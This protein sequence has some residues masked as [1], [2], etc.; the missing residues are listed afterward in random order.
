MTDGHRRN[1][2]PR[3]A[4][5]LEAL[6]AD[7]VRLLDTEED[8]APPPRRPRTPRPAAPAST[9]RGRAVEDAAA[10]PAP[11]SPASGG[12]ARKSA[13]PALVKVPLAGL[14]VSAAVVEQA[15]R[16]WVACATWPAEAVE[17]SMKASKDAIRPWLT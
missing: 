16:W 10:P 17:A 1:G 2:A 9:S 5:R 7:L 6:S 12:S 4:D 8:D 3:K 15:A 14:W 13:V 11:G